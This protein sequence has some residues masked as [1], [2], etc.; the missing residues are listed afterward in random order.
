MT[1]AC[2][3]SGIG[4]WELAAQQCG[5]ETVWAAEWDE[6]KAA[7][8]RERFPSVAL[9]GDV[10]KLDGHELKRRHGPIRFLFGSPP[11]TDISAAN[12]RG[13]GV[14][15]DESRLYFEAIRL[16]GEIRPD[17]CCF[18][19]S[20]RLRVRGAD[21]V[22]AALEREGYACWP[23]VVAAGH[24]GAPHIRRRS[25]L[26]AANSERIGL[27][28]QSG[29]SGGEIGKGPTIPQDNADANGDGQ[30]RLS[31][32]AEMGG[33]E[34]VDRINQ[35]SDRHWGEPADASVRFERRRSQVGRRQRGPEE[36]ETAGAVRKPCHSDRARLAE[37]QGF[38]GHDGQEQSTAQRTASSYWDHSGNS[39][40]RHLCLVDGVS[41]RMARQW[42][43]A[44]GDAVVVPVVAGIIRGILKVE[45]QTFPGEGVTS[46]LR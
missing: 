7:R 43:S 36:T 17:W 25:W 44:Y 8:Y 9:Y 24:A 21:R 2:L 6:W 28:D 22:C 40:A 42:R 27:R 30:S 14:D 35:S 32:D 13:Q 34:G 18:E 37:W 10:E 33:G 41:P 4:G 39:L 38:A 19:N 5:I 3:F 11:C 23:L 45:A 46:P 31:V 26:V 15:G 12:H 1:A 29:R 20:D 16:A